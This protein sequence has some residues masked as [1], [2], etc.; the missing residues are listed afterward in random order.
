MCMK[1]KLT[2]DWKNINELVIF[3]FVKAAERYS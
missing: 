3:G 1:Y 2:D